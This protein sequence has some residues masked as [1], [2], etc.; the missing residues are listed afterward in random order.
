MSAYII[1]LEAPV[2]SKQWQP[3]IFTCEGVFFFFLNRKW[4]HILR[5]VRSMRSS[6][7]SA[8]I[9]SRAKKAAAECVLQMFPP[10]PLVL[11]CRLLTNDPVPWSVHLTLPSLALLSVITTSTTMITSSTIFHKWVTG[12]SDVKKA[13]YPLLPADRV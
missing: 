2:S 6:R 8:R 10:E 1:C 7:K 9:F 13:Q 3:S 4:P 11:M 5:L 12:A